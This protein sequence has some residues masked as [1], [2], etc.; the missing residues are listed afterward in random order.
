MFFISLCVILL[1]SS[2]TKIVD[3]TKEVNILQDGEFLYVPNSRAIL[4]KKP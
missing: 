1:K 4:L 3:Q 2:E